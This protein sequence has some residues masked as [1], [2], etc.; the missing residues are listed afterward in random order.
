MRGRKHSKTF[1]NI[2]LFGFAVNR[3]D[4]IIN[5]HG[6]MVKSIIE[7]ICDGIADI[8][9]SFSIVCYCNYFNRE[10]EKG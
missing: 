8:D 2:G 5:I 4:G 9:I 10:E 6:F 3:I 1:W 7:N